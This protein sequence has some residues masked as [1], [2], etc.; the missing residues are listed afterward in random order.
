MNCGIALFIYDRPQCTEKVLEALKRNHID[1]LYVFQDGLGDQTNKTAWKRN[2][3]LIR[4]IDWCRVIYERNE[5]KASSLDTQ[6]I[7]GINKVFQEKEEIIVIEDDCV[8]SDDCIDFF[9]KCFETYRNNKKVISIDAYLEP[10]TVPE[11]Y[12]LSV[13]AS[14]APSSWGWGTWKDRWEEFQKDYEIVKRIG[15]SVKEYEGF[16][17]CGYPIKR[18]LTGYWMLRTWDLWWSINV[19]VREGI[20]IR[21]TYNKVYNIGFENPGTH[22]SGKSIWVVPIQQE[23][24]GQDMFPAKIEVEPWAKVEFAK[25]YQKANRKTGREERQTYYRKC[26]E[27]WVEIKQ[28]GKSISTLLA[29]KEIGNIAIYGT[30]SIGKLL[31]NELEEQNRIFYFIVTN[32]KSKHFMGYPVYDC[33]EDIPEES[34]DLS[35]L[36]IPGYELEEIKTAIGERF[37]RVYSLEDILV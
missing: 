18:I 14:G 15:K 32:K 9:V 1:E 12:K 27:R 31:I 28:Q 2:E 3:V 22:T 37:G 29:D 35:L 34:A 6:I 36:V 8:I 11:D 30:G 24:N 4:E 33:D 16:N 21:P 17:D 19:L 20:S 10:I 26:L 23:K 13:I 5:H 25:F 7:Y